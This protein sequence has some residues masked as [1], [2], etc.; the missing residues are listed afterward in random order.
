MEVFV[1]NQGT[2]VTSLL[3]LPAFQELERNKVDSSEDD[4]VDWDE[5]NEPPMG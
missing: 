3:S 4:Q 1:I 2:F 5:E